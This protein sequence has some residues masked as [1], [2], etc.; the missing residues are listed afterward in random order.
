MKVVVSLYK[1][2]RKINER[3][4]SYLYSPIAKFILYLNG[5]EYGSQ[6]KVS[7]FLQVYVTRRGSLTIGN[8]CTINSG[9]KHNV[10]GRQQRNIFWVEGELEIGN[11]VGISCSAIIC[12]HKIIIGDNVIIGGNTVVYDTDFH[13]LDLDIR[14]CGADKNFAAKAPVLI[15]DDV[16]IGAHTTILKGVTIGKGSVI[17]AGSVVARNVPDGEIWAGNPAVFLRKI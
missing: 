3:F 12:N 4:L 16:F 8:N 9:R 13:S 5:C 7:G 11:N 1:A 2:L 10:I 14:K 6:L 17:G 15:K